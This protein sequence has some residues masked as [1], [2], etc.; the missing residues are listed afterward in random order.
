M[1]E[2]VKTILWSDSAKTS[3]DNIIQYLQKEWTD[4]EVKR[5]IT[6]TEEML[7]VLRRYPEMSRPS[8]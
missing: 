3:F 6:R 4:R 5:F 7:G 8:L 2:V 1:E